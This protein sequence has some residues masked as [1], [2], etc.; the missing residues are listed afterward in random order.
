MKRIL[1]ATAMFLLVSQSAIGANKV[2]TTPDDTYLHEARHKMQARD[3]ASAF[4]CLEAFAKRY[5]TLKKDATDNDKLVHSIYATKFQNKVYLLLLGSGLADEEPKLILA[6]PKGAPKSE[7][8]QAIERRLTGRN[9]LTS[10]TDS[11]Q[12]KSA[13]SFEPWCHYALGVRAMS[14]KDFKKAEK[15]F[16]AV[17]SPLCMDIELKVWSRILKDFCASHKK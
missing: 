16:E 12:V 13:E 2:L 11:T 4:D 7:F 6:L 10:K 9:G 1:L 17:S 15:E 8:W 3:F 5:Q 14:T